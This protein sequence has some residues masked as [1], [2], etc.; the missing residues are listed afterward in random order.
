MH[1]SFSEDHPSSGAVPLRLTLGV[2][3]S[4]WARLPSVYPNAQDTRRE[5]SRHRL[6]MAPATR[7][8]TGILRRS[9]AQHSLVS[10]C[11]PV[12]IWTHTA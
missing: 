8:N 4:A 1:V 12:L 10:T 3:P 2:L 11:S 7:L 5:T 6:M 9:V